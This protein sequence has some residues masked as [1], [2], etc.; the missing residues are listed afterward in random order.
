MAGGA[1]RVVILAALV[2]LAAPVWGSGHGHAHKRRTGG[3][4]NRLRRTTFQQNTA[5]KGVRDLEVQ[6]ALGAAL[7]A[8][9]KGS[10]PS[11]DPRK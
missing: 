7:S 2:A 1:R 3:L 9:K 4:L 10:I 6:R 8:N 11:P 5:A